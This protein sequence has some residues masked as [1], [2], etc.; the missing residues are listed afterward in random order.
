MNDKLQQQYRTAMDGVHAPA[1]L[2]V[3]VRGLNRTARWSSSGWVR[4]AVSGGLAAALALAVANGAAYAVTGSTWVEHLAQTVLYFHDG[5]EETQTAVKE[6]DARIDLSSQWVTGEDSED[7]AIDWSTPEG[8]AALQALVA[9]Q[10]DCSDGSYT[11]LLDETGSGEDGWLRQVVRLS[12]DYLRDHYEQNYLADDAADLTAL[13]PWGEG[14]DL[15][16]VGRHYDAVPECSWLGLRYTNSMDAP[17]SAA[18]LTGYYVSDDGGL[19]QLWCAYDSGAETWADHVNEEELDFHETYTTA[20]GV[21]VAFLGR[22]S[23]IMGELSLEGMTLYLF[24]TDLT[25]TELEEVADHLELAALVEGYADYLA[26]E[27]SLDKEG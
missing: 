24:G 10:F 3:R 1:E 27:G 2:E 8:V 23:R 15:S 21:T 18:Y 13:L 16:W 14:W 7:D 9:D 20:D 25:L 4:K 26:G 19:L 6:E 12:S 17:V 11:C 22:D 5:E